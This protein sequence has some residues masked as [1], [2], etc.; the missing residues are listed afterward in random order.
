MR[1]LK[2]LAKKTVFTI[3]P[4]VPG[5]PIEEVKRELGLKEVIKLAS[6]ENPYGPSPKVLK[7]I[8]AA[9]LQI[10]RYPDGNCFYL[11]KVLS[12]Y[13][14]VAPNQ[15][16]FGNGSDEL[17]VLAA[18]LFVN[19]GDEVISA[20][21]SF[22][23]Y[24]I[25]SKIAGANIKSIPL[26]NFHYDLDGMKKAITDKTRIIFLGNPD[27]PSGTYLKQKDVERFLEGIPE[28]ILIFFDEAYYE[29]VN[30][31][32]YVDSIKL[33]KKHKN[34]IVTRTFSKMYGLAGLRV[35]YGIA[36][37]EVCDLFDRMREPFNINSI[38]QA[39][40]MTCLNDQKYYQ[41]VAKKID[42]QRNFLYE[43]FKKLKLNF[44]P[45]STNFTL[46]KVNGDASSVVKK[47]MENGIIVRDMSTWGMEH[48]IRITVG[49]KEENQKLVKAL[50]KI[51]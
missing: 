5:K 7:A 19:E 23:I 33:L 31:K 24:D 10:N 15:L 20:K 41:N 49:S 28:D 47:L 3:K 38:A 13:L 35:G 34:V 40:A 32:D 6:N 25:A 11:R 26:N 37:P 44:Q 30:A 36:H 2:N 17:I 48:Y 21:P 4:Y 9:A 42:T 29:Y 1:D 16:I 39:A 46:V 45:S 51:L 14:N 43:S 50:G 27:N 18:R 8:H 12:Q 22:L